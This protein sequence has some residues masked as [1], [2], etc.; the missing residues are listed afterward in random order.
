MDS[1]IVWG[2]VVVVVLVIAFFIYKKVITKPA[3]TDDKPPK[4]EGIRSRQR[5]I[6]K[7]MG[8]GDSLIIYFP[9]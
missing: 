2:I 8:N 4:A 1:K 5:D 9:S 7:E 6:E 3:G